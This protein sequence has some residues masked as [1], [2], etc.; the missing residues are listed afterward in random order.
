MRYRIIC[1]VKRPCN[2]K[3]AH[4]FIEYYVLQVCLD[5]VDTHT[6]Y[7]E[8]DCKGFWLGPQRFVCG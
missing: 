8:S 5:Y 3:D 2:R 6:L 7:E 1:I 4:M